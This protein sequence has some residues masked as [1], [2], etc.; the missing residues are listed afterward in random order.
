MLQAYGR[1]VLDTDDT[2]TARRKIEAEIRR[3]PTATWEWLNQS[4]EN[5]LGDLRVSQVLPGAWASYYITALCPPSRAG[6]LA[7]VRVYSYIY[8]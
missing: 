7:S 1:T 6:C 4:D 3:L 8:R 5:R 2:E